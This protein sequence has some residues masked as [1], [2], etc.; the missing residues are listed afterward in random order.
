MHCSRR[1]FLM[2]AILGVRTIASQ[3]FEAMSSHRFMKVA[4]IRFLAAFALA[5]VAA[6]CLA[7]QPTYLPGQGYMDPAF[8]GQ[9]VM[10]PYYAGFMPG[11]GAYGYGAYGFGNHYWGAG[12]TVLGSQMAGMADAI[13]AQ[14]QYNLMTAYGNVANQQARTA[15]IQNRQ[16]AAQTYFEMRRMN[17]QYT[18]AER[19][20]NASHTSP[21]EV[22]ALRAPRSLSPSQ[23]DPV[24]GQIEWPSALMNPM[25]D[26]DR[27]M[28]QAL[29]SQR[30]EGV[31]DPSLT[32]KIDSVANGM[33]SKLL[34]EIK[35][36]P[37]D[38]YIAA[39]SLLD[40]LVYAVHSPSA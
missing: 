1:Q 33:R 11:S 15:S 14:G 8:R 16:L 7:Q 32:A 9:P 36:L 39:K 30:A 25:F 24:T 31:Y 38:A 3:R 6:P 27:Q 28:L 26:N 17:Q 2:D 29:F 20:R 35:N 4:T 19:A 37:P 22:A 13:A 5:A 21:A 34:S 23:L 12:S 18:S 10:G 40:S